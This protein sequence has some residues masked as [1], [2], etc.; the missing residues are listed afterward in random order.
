MSGGLFVKRQGIGAAGTAIDL[1]NETVRKT[2]IRVLVNLPCSVDGNRLTYSNIDGIEQ[3]I[4]DFTDC[5]SIYLQLLF[6]N[7]SRLGH[8]DWVYKE[9]GAFGPNRLF[10]EIDFLFARPD[11]PFSRP[12]KPAQ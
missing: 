11:I 7:P 4:D 10:D 8:Y 5:S 1:R 2:D 9:L 3:P 12:N 6:Q